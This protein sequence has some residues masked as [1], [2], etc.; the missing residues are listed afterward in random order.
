MNDYPQK[1][2]LLN[3][4]LG[5][6]TSREQE[7]VERWLDQEQGNISLLQQAAGELRQK[8][9]YPI[10]GKAETKQEILRD[11]RSK[12]TVSKRTSAISG[13]QRYKLG[14]FWF[15]IAA[16]VLVIIMSGLAGIYF[17]YDQYPAD[18]ATADSQPEVVF[19]QSTLANGQTASLQF[20]DGSVI[21]LNGG[22]TLRYP[23]TFAEDR[24]EVYLEGEA[25][26]SIARDETRPFIVHAGN[27]TTRVLGTSFNIRAYGEDS[28]LQVVVAE[29]KVAVTQSDIFTGQNLTA[30]E[31]AS[32]IQADALPEQGEIVYLERDQWM[33]YHTAGQILEKGEG[34]IQEMIA[35]KDR[36]LVFC[37]KSFGQVAEMLERWYGVDIII[38]DPVL[39]SYILEG[40]HHDVSLEEVLKSIQFVMDFDYSI[41]GN[42]ILIDKGT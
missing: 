18:E 22:S 29:G 15:K 19:K 33:T 8:E 23:E 31:G 41:N 12:K 28:E 21:K 13:R 36:I 10:P 37:N 16:M 2:L 4:L 25:F 42:E 5:I 1:Q 6:C 24:R 17:G 9:E 3:Y 14:E 26:F 38:E 34:N 35:W 32:D 39:K 40:E 20:G 30:L 7:K 27:T 11:I